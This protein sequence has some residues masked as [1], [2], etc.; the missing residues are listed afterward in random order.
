M[1]RPLLCLALLL[2]TACG[3]LAADEHPGEAAPAAA[4]LAFPDQQEPPR[5]GSLEEMM[6]RHADVLQVA[7]NDTILLEMQ[8]R[9]V[10]IHPEEED[11]DI[12]V[13]QLLRSLHKYEGRGMSS[14]LTL[15]D[16]PPVTLVETDQS[17]ADPGLAELASAYRDLLNTT[18]EPAIRLQARHRLADI[19]ML[20]GEAALALQEPGD[21]QAYFAE[22]IRTYTTLLRENPGYPANDQLLYQLAKAHA[23]SSESDESI[24]VLDRLSSGYPASP[25]IPEAEFRK[26][27]S[28]FTAADYGRADLA[29]TRVIGYGE[30][31]PYYTNALYMQ[32][33]SRLKKG[34]YRGAVEPFTTT[35]DLVMPA[36]NNRESIEPGER[37]LAGDSL[38]ALAVIFSQLDGAQSIDLAYDRLGSRAYQPLLYLQ[39]GDLY[40]AQERYADSA[41]AY[42]AYLR[43]F[44]DS[45]EAPG[46]QLRVIAAYEAGGFAELV[47]QEKQVFLERFAL[48]S[49]YWQHSGETQRAENRTYLQQF[50]QE[51]AQY[52]HALAQQQAQPGGQP[53]TATEH[54]L[55]AI[56]YYQA[57]IESFPEDDRVATMGFL[58]G[59]CRFEVGDFTGAIAAYERVAYDFSENAQAADAAYAAIL[60][61]EQL[62]DEAE[63]SVEQQRIASER[64]FAAAFDT[65][66][67]ALPVLEHVAASLLQMDEFALSAEVAATVIGWQPAPDASAL[68]AARLVQGHSLFELQRY[69]DAEQAYREALSGMPAEDERY[70]ESVDRLAASIYRQGEEAVAAGDY[71]EAAGQ[72]QRVIASAPLSPH[73]INAQFDAATNYIRAGELVQANELLLDFR[74]Q[75]PNHE[76][77]ASIGPNLVSNYEQ[78]ELWQAAAIELDGIAEEQPQETQQRQALYLSASYYDRFGAT[79]LAIQRYQSYAKRWPAPFDTQ[80]EAMYRLAELYQQVGETQQQR[81]WLSKI[82]AAHDQAGSNRSERSL[83]LAA[84]S[85][86]ILADYEYDKFSSIKLGYPIKASLDRKRAAMKR[87]VEAYKKTA[88]YGV[89]QLSTLATYRMG[90]IYQQ[91]GADLLDS[92]RPDNL[93]GMALEQYEVLLEEQAYPFEEKAIAIY[94]SNARRSREGIYDEWVRKSFTALGELLPVRYHKLEKSN[95]Y[96]REIY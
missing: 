11:F 37:E 92:D 45:S 41:D 14:G 20:Q 74:H 64:R 70:P 19:M 96:S 26:A 65:D 36:D 95:G 50:M 42:K 60:A 40:L 47:V 46:V 81:S 27:E 66:P 84:L 76:L 25:Y 68:T 72:F 62:G 39:L 93:N 21:G 12:F 6:K 52:H 59:E 51:L 79:E 90:R 9:Q 54:Y 78:M 23:L 38:R 7:P 94:E 67:R 53:A 33:W 44:P 56:N 28:F 61:Y 15:Q 77:V 82:A 8:R 85:A 71:A 48:E 80:I 22:S 43:S 87:A 57:F 3:A 49:D 2:L 75:F 10:D 13:I 30:A 69:S 89:E 86:S 88:A 31:T 73:R 4:S 16:L 55:A 29:Y 83:Y 35:L 34:D 17:I 63:A 58:L 24:A 91:L 5:R 1:N 32:G 18:S